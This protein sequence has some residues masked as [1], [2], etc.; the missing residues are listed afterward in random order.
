MQGKYTKS[1]RADQDIRIIIIRSMADFGEAQT[2][3]YIEGLESALCELAE[4]PD[5]GRSFVSDRTGQEYSRYRYVSHVVYY[6]KRQDD[7]FIV[8]ILHGKMLPENH[9]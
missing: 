8:R 9:L 2:D 4:A 5:K 1:K 3:K 7:I 6:R